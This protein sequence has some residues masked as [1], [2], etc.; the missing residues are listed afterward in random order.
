MNTATETSHSESFDAIKAA[1]NLSGQADELETYYDQ[2]AGNYDQ[3]VS[4]E[5]YIGP[6]FIAAYLD[7]LSGDATGRRDYS[8]S[9]LDAGCGTGLVGVALKRLGYIH[10]DGFDLSHKM[11]DIASETGCYGALEGGC[12]MTQ[13]IP[14]YQD[15][16][17]DASVS[18]GVFTLG[19][20]PPQSL[21]EMIRFTKPGGLIVVSTRLSYYN[22]TDFQAECDRLQANNIVTLT[23][24][25]KFGPYIAEEGA[26]YWAF[27]VH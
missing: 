10:V 1:H 4:N 12:D 16:Q 22:S 2:W 14:A 15:N 24:F 21:A 19:H 26:H 25:V 27:R 5:A 18:C 20:V 11:V 8:M 23:S 13:I 17:Y 3:D 7:L 6:N 9:I